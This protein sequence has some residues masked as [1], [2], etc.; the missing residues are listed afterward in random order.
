MFMDAMA[1]HGPLRATCRVVARLSRHH[2]SS[3]LVT[4]SRRTLHMHPHSSTT[5]ALIPVV[6]G[7]V[8]PQ[9]FMPATARQALVQ[10]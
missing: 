2:R 5:G 3:S 4:V 1:P 6:G 9:A 7:A 8:Q 10:G